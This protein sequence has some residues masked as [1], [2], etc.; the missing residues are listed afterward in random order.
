MLNSY[1]L[2][3]YLSVNTIP[4]CYI[5]ATITCNW[6]IWDPSHSHRSCK[7]ATLSSTIFMI[8]SPTR[9]CKLM[10]QRHRYCTCH[11]MTLNPPYCVRLW[12]NCQNGYGNNLV[13]RETRIGAMC[14]FE[15]TY[16]VKNRFLVVE[17][18]RQASG[19]MLSNLDLTRLDDCLNRDDVLSICDFY[20]ECM[21][22]DDG[23]SI[24]TSKRWHR[25]KF[26]L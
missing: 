24:W 21:R 13:N 26:C 23:N 12:S 17:R 3:Q 6:N 5:V 10:K 25:M 9:F 19:R 22:N 18:W 4:V 16:L 14:C 11:G 1:Q 8:Y 2:T 15:W 20:R 7:D